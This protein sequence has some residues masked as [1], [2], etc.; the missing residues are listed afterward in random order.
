MES[1]RFNKKLWV[2]LW[3]L[4]DFL[5]DFGIFEL[6]TELFV[7]D[8]YWKKVSSDSHENFGISSLYVCTQLFGLKPIYSWKMVIFRYF[9]VFLVPKPK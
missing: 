4:P 5:A 1:F 9:L 2:D 7:K 3:K 8:S 6:V